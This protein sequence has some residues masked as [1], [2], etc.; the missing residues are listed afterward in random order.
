[1]ALANGQDFHLA[2][3]LWRD[4]KL[5]RIGING[6]RSSSSFRRFY[7]DGDMADCSHAEMDAL[8]FYKPGD[9]LEVFRWTKNGKLALAKPC[10]YC[11][12]R[13]KRLKVKVRYTNSKGEW[14]SL[15]L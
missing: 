1:M 13:I 10:K 15:S 9:R 2:A 4:N 6:I 7:S 12:K 5:I 14:E 8:Q 11:M 3:L